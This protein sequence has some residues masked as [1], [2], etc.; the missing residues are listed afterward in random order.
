MLA[1]QAHIEQHHTGVSPSLLGLE[2][3]AVL[4]TALRTCLVSSRK[5]WIR[6]DVFDH[7]CR[8][9]DMRYELVPVHPGAVCQFRVRAVPALVEKTLV[10][11]ILLGIE[12]VVA[13]GTEFERHLDSTNRCD[14]PEQSR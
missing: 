5:R 7:T 1:L 10:L 9:T 6:S 12:H 4:V 8:F 3:H 14:E 2:E 11:L 13:F